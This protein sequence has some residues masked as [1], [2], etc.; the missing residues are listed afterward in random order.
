VDLV[1]FRHADTYEV[2]SECGCA[3]WWQ[4]HFFVDDMWTVDL[5][6]RIW[7]QQVLFLGPIV[8]QERSE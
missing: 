3:V 8:S 2:H 6:E 5:P 1:V 4:S 7:V